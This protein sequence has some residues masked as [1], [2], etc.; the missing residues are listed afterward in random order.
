MNDT[1]ILELFPTVVDSLG[2]WTLILSLIFIPIL[3]GAKAFL[4]WLEWNMYDKIK[5]SIIM[6]A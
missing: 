1:V 2:V 6:Y 5:S 4:M 3:I